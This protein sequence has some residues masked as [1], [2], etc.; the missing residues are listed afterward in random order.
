ME[1]CTPVASQTK[2]TFTRG[3]ESAL[4]VQSLKPRIDL[5]KARY[6]EDQDKISK[7]TSVLYEQAGVN[8]LAGENITDLAAALAGSRFGSSSMSKNQQL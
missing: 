3:V 7:E 4:A 8:P 5:I 6:G 1:G 2:M